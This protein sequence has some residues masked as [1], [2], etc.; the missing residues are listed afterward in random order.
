MSWYI[1]LQLSLWPW[2]KVAVELF[3]PANNLLDLLEWVKPSEQFV[4]LKQ[5]Q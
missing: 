1:Q 5:Q 4:L 2:R 3:S